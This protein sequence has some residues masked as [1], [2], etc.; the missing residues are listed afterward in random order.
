MTGKFYFT[1]PKPVGLG[2]KLNFI[3]YNTRIHVCF[4]KPLRTPVTF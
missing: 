4:I 2:I 3:H 1:L